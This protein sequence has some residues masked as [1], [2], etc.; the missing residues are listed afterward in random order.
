[1]DSVDADSVTIRGLSSTP[2]G[3]V[4]KSFLHETPWTNDKSTQYYQGAKYYLYYPAAKLLLLLITFLGLCTQIA[5]GKSFLV[6]LVILLTYQRVI[7]LTMGFVTIPIMDQAC[8]VSP[9]KSIINIMNCTCYAQRVDAE[10]V[11]F[12]LNRGFKTMPKF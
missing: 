3:G 9:S 7:A 4:Q 8:F 10:I 5:E 1:M 12:N 2:A 6:C 11:K